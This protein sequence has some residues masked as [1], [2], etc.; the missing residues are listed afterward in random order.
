MVGIV[1]EISISIHMLQLQYVPG[2]MS[3]LSLPNQNPVWLSF[4]A[5]ALLA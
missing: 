1:M 5:A 2:G 3:I 4:H